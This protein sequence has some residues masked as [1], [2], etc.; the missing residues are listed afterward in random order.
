M[1]CKDSSNQVREK[2]DLKIY[3]VESGD[4]YWIYRKFNP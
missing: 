4:I 3:A 2:P 1:I